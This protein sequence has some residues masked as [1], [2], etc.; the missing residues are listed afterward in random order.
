MTRGK[1]ALDGYDIMVNY[2]NL[3]AEYEWHFH[4]RNLTVELYMLEPYHERKAGL[5]PVCV[6]ASPVT[7]NLSL[8]LWSCPVLIFSSLFLSV[9]RSCPVLNLLNLQ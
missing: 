4:F 2:Q 9:W 1:S 6:S 8:T 7:L 3:Y 5:E